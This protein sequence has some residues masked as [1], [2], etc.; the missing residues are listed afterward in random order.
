VPATRD[1][2]L[3]AHRAGQLGRAETL[4]RRALVDH[5]DDVDC[6][7]MLG[8]V[9]MERLRYREALGLL[10]NAAERTA[11]SSSQIRHNLGLALGKLMTAEANARQA[12]LLAEFVEWQRARPPVQADFTPLVS[13]VMRAHGDHGDV[14]AAIESV[15]HRHLDYQKG[16]H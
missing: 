8:V 2:A 5:P 15:V 12:E 14:A 9:Q 11:W 10:W 3:A 1:Q 4:Y 7:H 13:V 6:T 16:N